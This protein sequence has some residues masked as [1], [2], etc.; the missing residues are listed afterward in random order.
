ML[1]TA[2]VG[3]T[4][5]VLGVYDGLELRHTWRLS[6]RP[7]RTADELALQ[8]SGFLEHRDLDLRKDV[9]GACVASVVPD[10]HSAPAGRPWQVAG[11]RAAGLQHHQG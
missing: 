11:D 4:E 6:T 8:L 2:D 1:L 7:E 5:I 3:N 9:T 10:D